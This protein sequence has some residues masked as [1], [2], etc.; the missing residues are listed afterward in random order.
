MS[1]HGHMSLSDIPVSD[2]WYNN[3]VLA[4]LHVLHELRG[5]SV[6]QLLN[7]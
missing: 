2:L 1:V 7:R 6:L 3:G 4:K 5:H